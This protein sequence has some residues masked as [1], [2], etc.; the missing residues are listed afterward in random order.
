MALGKEPGSLDDTFVLESGD[1]A[2]G[3]LA[4]V[5]LNERIQIGDLVCQCLFSEIL[6]S[7]LSVS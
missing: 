7:V 6:K 3:C 2:E 1:L 4:P 5:G